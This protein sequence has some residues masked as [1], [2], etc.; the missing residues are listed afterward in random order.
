MTLNNIRQ[1]GLIP[2]LIANGSSGS[3]LWL[4]VVLCLVGGVAAYFLGSMNF[5]VIISKYKFHDDIRRYGSGNGGMT[6]MLRTYGKA[7]AGFT[8]LCDAAESAVI[9]A[10]RNTARR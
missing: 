7:A 4:I 3:P 1:N 10:L 5:A 8:L 9:G 6:N 2:M